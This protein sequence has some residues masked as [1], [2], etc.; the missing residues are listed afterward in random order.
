MAV[1][2]P[3][4]VP[5]TFNAKYVDTQIKCIFSCWS[6]NF[7]WV[8]DA[9]NCTISTSWFVIPMFVIFPVFL[10]KLF[11]DVLWKFEK[12]KCL[13]FEQLLLDFGVFPSPVHVQAV[14]D[15][16]QENVY[17]I[18]LLELKKVIPGYRWNNFW[19]AIIVLKMKSEMNRGYFHNNTILH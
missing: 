11:W 6:F 9:Q 15:W 5:I 12:Q 4:S 19:E 14:L 16:K 3:N 8:Q 2:S 10:S 18:C 17:F 13:R 1:P 7:L